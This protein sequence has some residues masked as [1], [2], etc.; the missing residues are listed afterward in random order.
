MLAR[1]IEVHNPDG[2]GRVLVARSQI[3]TG[4]PPSTTFWRAWLQPR[5]Q[6]SVHKHRPNGSAG[7]ME[8]TWE[9]ESSSRTGQLSSSVVVC[10]NP[11]PSFT[12]RVRAV[13]PAVV[14]PP[15]SLLFRHWHSGTV[16]LDVKNRHGQGTSYTPH[17][18]ELRMIPVQ[19]HIIGI[20]ESTSEASMPGCVWQQFS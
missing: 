16:H 19:L 6:A 20:T 4:P 3:Q 2:A 14:P 5:R 11:Q 10:V 18:R 15:P 1:V 12:S 7:S 8:A 13:W 17:N 9:V